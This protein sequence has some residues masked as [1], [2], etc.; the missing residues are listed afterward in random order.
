MTNGAKYI[1]IRAFSSY[2]IN[3]AIK[4]MDSSPPS[5]PN[6]QAEKI[7]ITPEMAER[8]SLNLQIKSRDHQWYLD[9]IR[10]MGDITGEH[11][12]GHSPHEYIFS[13]LQK[14]AEG[15]SELSTRV[16]TVINDHL[17]YFSGLLILPTGKCCDLKGITDRDR[18]FVSMVSLAYG[19]YM[20]HLLG[21]KGGRLMGKNIS[22]YNRASQK[23]FDALDQS[24]MLE[25]LS[26]HPFFDELVAE[27][28]DRESAEIEKRKMAGFSEGAQ[29]NITGLPLPSGLKNEFIQGVTNEIFGNIFV[30]YIRI[31]AR[32]FGAKISMGEGRLEILAEQVEPEVI[33]EIQNFLSYNREKT[34]QKV[35]KTPAINLEKLKKIIAQFF[36]DRGQRVIKNLIKKDLEAQM[37]I[38][39]LQAAMLLTGE[40]LNEMDSAELIHFTS[41]ELH[42]RIME[43][44]PDPA[45]TPETEQLRQKISAKAEAATETEDAA[46][47]KKVEESGGEQIGT[48]E[49][50]VEIT[51]EMV[52]RASINLQIRLRDGDWYQSFMQVLNEKMEGAMPS[53]SSFQKISRGLEKIAETSPASI[54]IITAV[55]THLPS[56]P[57]NVSGP[58][59]KCCDFAGMKKREK[60]FVSTAAMVYGWYLRHALG[61]HNGKRM[62][63]YIEEYKKEKDKNMAYFTGP[64]IL[65]FLRG[66]PFFNELIAEA[67][68]QESAEEEKRKFAYLIKT[69]TENINNLPV[70][71]SVIEDFLG[72]I[73]YNV[74]LIIHNSFLDV[75]SGV[76]KTGVKVIDGRPQMAAAEKDAEIIAEVSRELNMDIDKKNAEML[77]GPVLNLG[78]IKNRLVKTFFEKSVNVEKILRKRGRQFQPLARTFQASMLLTSEY[79]DEI[80]PETLLHYTCPEFFNKLMASLPDPAPP[81]S[82]DSP[83]PLTSPSNENVEI[84]PELIRLAEANFELLSQDPEWTVGFYGLILRLLVTKEAIDIKEDNPLEN[85]LQEKHKVDDGILSE[86]LA[87]MGMDIAVD[88]MRPGI[89]FDQFIEEIQKK[90]R[91]IYRS[92]KMLLQLSVNRKFRKAGQILLDRGVRKISAK[93]AKCDIATVLEFLRGTP[94]YDSLTKPDPDMAALHEF[95]GKMDALTTALENDIGG[96]SLPKEQREDLISELVERQNIEVLMFFDSLA[97][98]ALMRGEKRKEINWRGRVETP[99]NHGLIEWAQNN[100]KADL[101]AMKLALFARESLTIHDIKKELSQYCRETIVDLNEIKKNE[102]KSFE[103]KHIDGMITTYGAAIEYIGGLNARDMLNLIDPKVIR[104]VLEHMVLP[105]EKSAAEDALPE[106]TESPAKAE[107]TPASPSNESLEMTPEIL[108]RAFINLQ[109]RSRDPGWDIVVFQNALF[110]GMMREP[111]VMSLQ[112]RLVDKVE[113]TAMELNQDIPL[114]EGLESLFSSIVSKLYIYRPRCMDAPGIIQLERMHKQMH[115]Q[116]LRWVLRQK[117][118]RI[119]IKKMEKHLDEYAKAWDGFLKAADKAR[120]LDWI[121]E[122]SIHD[123]L[124]SANPDPDDAAMGKRKLDKVLGYARQ[125]LNDI[126]VPESLRLQFARD[127]MSI[128]HSLFFKSFLNAICDIKSIEVSYNGA[129]FQ[130]K[131]NDSQDENFETTMDFAM[132]L[133]TEKITDIMRRNEPCGFERIKSVK[134]AHYRVIRASIDGMLKQ[135]PQQPYR[136]LILAVRDAVDLTIK[137][138]TDMDADLIVQMGSLSTYNEIIEAIPDPAQEIVHGSSAPQTVA[139]AESK[140]NGEDLSEKEKLYL[141]E[142]LGDFYHLDPESSE[143]SADDLITAIK[144]Q[145]FIEEWTEDLNHLYRS[146]GTAITA[147]AVE[148]YLRENLAQKMETEES[149]PPENR[150]TMPSSLMRRIES[151]VDDWNK[152]REAR[153]ERRKERRERE[154][155]EEKRNYSPRRQFSDK[156]GDCISALLSDSVHLRVSSL[157]QLESLAQTLELINSQLIDRADASGWQYKSV[158]IKIKPVILA[159]SA[160]AGE[161]EPDENILKLRDL[162]EEQKNTVA[163]MET[164]LEAVAG[165]AKEKEI[166][167]AKISDYH[168][169]QQFVEGSAARLQKVRAETRKKL[170]DYFSRVA[171]DLSSRDGNLRDGLV[172]LE[173]ETAVAVE[174]AQK[175][176]EHLGNLIISAEDQLR[177]AG[178]KGGEAVVIEKD[179]EK[180]KN[181]MSAL[182]NDLL[183]LYN[184]YADLYF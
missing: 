64:A 39:A 59:W 158:S 136:F 81:L 66:T 54:E 121:K 124:V 24:A 143:Y 123:E 122:S 30:S 171:A 36:F 22:Q 56:L 12:S 77:D 166:N 183:S 164:E 131:M 174:K 173:E 99:E 154:P 16:S 21:R 52:E 43:A 28:P 40:F 102:N 148:K 89:T 169:E 157:T 71:K 51:P 100:R 74:D 153:M 63:K 20:R 19:W 117:M 26:K 150:F 151:A 139:R 144:E 17:P 130:L 25:F 87:G 8:I 14:I 32:V 104:S 119:G 34:T 116:V 49:T 127:I 140:N 142:A 88:R 159:L 60:G 41:H 58:L 3:P 184:E 179:I 146:G 137:Q 44:L 156:I 35:L 85:G 152:I 2:T 135:Y 10:H 67:P 38:K 98:S 163:G 46:T 83:A 69:A 5:N 80:S 107:A 182:Q 161:A 113:Q 109:I 93:I 168:E 176:I 33:E 82:A 53:D 27:E 72:E 48:P 145:G 167:E 90:S 172:E 103:T 86:Y 13:G 45:D 125:N 133:G 79:L 47:E 170:T 155:D 141:Q 84:T 165:G 50:R 95:R 37:I 73:F 1:I 94:V 128:I 105:V 55:N 138:L 65:E 126:P 62:E 96:L 29:K 177:L 110:T 129:K 91:L 18:M 42:A 175:E 181:E 75:V 147:D 68:D 57:A 9:F 7:E 120:I 180:R 134:I 106:S 111:K 160:N 132:E 23:I 115:V 92:E 97:Q 114:N 118:G 31:T 11:F 4:I 78:I 76:M 61:R 162:L 15:S 6:P 101:N 108:D 178:E 149:K 112:K 70:P